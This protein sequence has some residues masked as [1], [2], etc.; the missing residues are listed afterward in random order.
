[1]KLLQVF[2][3]VLLTANSFQLLAQQKRPPVNPTRRST[4][5]VTSSAPAS[6]FDNFLPSETYK[7]YIEVRGVGQVIRSNSFSDVIDPVL[8]L[9]GPPKEFRTFIKW[10]NTHAEEV[11]TSRMFLATWTSKKNLPEAIIAIEFPSVEEATKFEP[12]LNTFL[13]KV[14][15]TP[16]PPPT[17]SPTTA[18]AE[19]KTTQSQPAKS[20]EPPKPRYFLKRFGS[21]IVLTPTELKLKTLRPV[22]S[23]PLSEDPT[24]RTARNRFTS[25]QLFAFVDFKIITREDEERKK[26]MRAERKRAEEEAASQK[27]ETVEESSSQTTSP[28][29]PELPPAPEEPP[30]SD[31]K[32]QPPELM[33]ALGS[34]FAGSFFSGVASWP[35]AIGIAASL[36]PDSFDV[37]LLLINTPGEKV[38]PIPLLPNLITAA[39]L[40]TEAPSVLPADTE[41][42]VSM[43][44]DL[45][46]IYSA[47]SKPK[48]PGLSEAE[49]QTVKLDNAGVFSELEQRLKIDIAKDLLPL[50]GNEVAVTMSMN[51]LDIAPTSPPK[52]NEATESNADTSK[53]S[54]P[55][56]VIALSL[57]D[58]EG[59]RTLLPRI[60][61]GLGFK[62]VGALATTERRDET[63]TV[64]Y[65]NALS[66]A[67]I[68]NFIVISTDANAV[69]HVVDSY[70]KQETL[71]SDVQFKNFSRWQPRQVQAQVYI[72]PALMESYKTWAKEPTTLLSDQTRDFMSRL[73]VVAHPV[74]YSL[75][76]DG[77][78]VLHEVHV[79]KDLVLMAVA[80]LAEGSNPPETVSNERTTIAA[81]YMISH[82][83]DQY[84]SGKGAGSYGTLDQL[85]EEDMVQKD[86]IEK[87]GYKIE[88]TLTGTRFEITAVPTEYGKTGKTSYYIDQ[89]GVLRGA[90]HA[91]ATATMSD[92]RIQQ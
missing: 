91:G 21:L 31:Q 85:I 4:P 38:D 12:Q 17:P 81:L 86:L 90:D 40:A 49:W 27:N 84:K 45:P 87:H 2:L 51:Y 26:E 22:S 29:E 78:G 24:F 89:T 69:R 36:E 44:L 63:E 82:A 66:Y 33:S 77:A 54:G 41:F 64:S 58:K 72:S 30:P 70:L 8:K 88:L 18:P 56:P 65:G 15:P 16:G 79:P 60:V 42:L 52:D 28:P 57:R 67:F 62:G 34:I 74:T 5:S 59:M 35:Q 25:E 92:R 19:A 32:P 10:L 46:Q 80:G 37:R 76:T 83:Q 73:G 1:M 23:K 55:S 3:C 68:K 11:A 13:P 6:T 7:L 61:E 53:R 43:S 50:L 71:S 9:A 14:L 20:D 39:P 48:L 47:M 75:S